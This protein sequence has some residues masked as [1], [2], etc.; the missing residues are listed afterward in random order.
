M[1]NWNIETV[2]DA[3][4]Y[5]AN[6]IAVD[7]NNR[8]HIV[9]REF[10]NRDLKYAVNASV[11]EYGPDGNDPLYD[12][13]GNGM[14]DCQEK[15]VAS[16]HTY[17]G[18]NYVTLAAP[19]GITLQNIEPVG[20]PSPINTPNGINFPF[21]FIKFIVADVTPGDAITVELHLPAGTT[22]S[23]YY[24]YGPTPLNPMPHWYDFIFDGTTGAIIS[25]NIVTLYLVDGLRGDYDLTV[26][27]VIVEP[28]A[29]G[30][31]EVLGDLDDDGDVDG[32]D[33]LVLI[34]SLR[35]CT[36]DTGFNSDADLDTDGCVTFT[37][38]RQWYIYYKAFLSGS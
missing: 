37:D 22:I 13:D 24:K 6:N 36:G 14:P 28:G 9:Y 11:E 7:S 25:G 2:A 30:L 29:P 8:A 23:N 18:T 35:K 27:G 16:F 4:A 38:Y 31:V 15:N 19:A 1:S 17:G 26:N 21:G 5:S 32:D 12:G 10:T 20:N 33:R 34:A 3:L